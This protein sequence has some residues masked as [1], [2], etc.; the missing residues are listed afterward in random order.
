MENA[1][2]K[3]PV[4]LFC[5]ED[6]FSAYEKQK[7]WKDRFVEKYGEMNIQLYYGDE[8][9]ARDFE[10]AVQTYPFLSEKKLLV[11]QDFLSEA[12]DEEVKK[13]AE[14]LESVP[15][16]CVVVFFEHKKPDARTAFYKRIAK[17][18]VLE[19]FDLKS[20]AELWRWVSG[21]VTA[22]GGKIEDM[23]VRMLTDLV[24]AN[25]WN[26]NNEIEKLVL[27][28]EGRTISGQMIKM[29]VSPNLTSTVFK[30]TDYL[31]EKRLSETLE[32]WRILIESGEELIAIMF[33]L[34]RHFR[35]M[36]QVKELVERGMKA[37][38]IAKE[39]KEHPFVVGKMV[40]QVRKFSFEEIRRIYAELGR[41]DYGFKTGR[42]KVST[43]DYSELQRAIEMLMVKALK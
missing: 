5:G 9:T 4:Y 23:E 3:L 2:E 22:L 6:S 20:G 26:L 28:A 14:M 10:N 25:L 40:G 27:F 29:L 31:G 33:M 11:V 32:V 30:L 37:G 18:G 7:L 42:I 19:V 36:A 24:G 34:V 17:K 21:R 16:F 41:I 15:E 35:I 43:G 39:I 13:V 8:L 38:E 1:S 12:R